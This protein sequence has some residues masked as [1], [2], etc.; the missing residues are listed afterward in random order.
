[1]KEGLR[2]MIRISKNAEQK[3]NRVFFM[4]NM[5]NQSEIEEFSIIGAYSRV[6]KSLR[7]QQD[8]GSR[9]SS[10]SSKVPSLDGKEI[11]HVE[12]GNRVH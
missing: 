8:P 10:Q 11:S 1:M 7:F 9:N 5:I 4:I 6:K 3:E 12:G 2:R